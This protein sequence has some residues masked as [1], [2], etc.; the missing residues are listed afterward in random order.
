MTTAIVIGATG[1]TGSS[2]TRHLL[3]AEQYRQVIVLSRRELAL[4]HDKL[5]NH[6]VNFDQPKKWQH[7]LQGDDLFSALGTTRKQAGSKHEQYRVDYTYQANAIQA[8]A[9]NGVQRLFLVSSPN[10]SQK[11]PLFYTK[12]KGKLEDF[13]RQQSFPTLAIFQPSLITGDRAD[14][15]SAEKLAAPV[16]DTLSRWIPGASKYRPISGAQ[17][18]QAIVACACSDL[19]PGEHTFVLGKIFQFLES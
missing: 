12:M 5:T 1:L 19:P 11:S 16:I 13:A 3:D 6:V 8:A 9:R 15:R 10:A 14:H 4:R 17:L 7:L 2:I 18:G